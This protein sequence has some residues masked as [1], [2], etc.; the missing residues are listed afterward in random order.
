MNLDNLQE[1][2]QGM[3]LR[4]AQQQ[5]QAQHTSSVEQQLELMVTACSEIDTALAQVQVA[6]QELHLDEQEL[7]LKNTGATEYQHYQKLFEFTLDSD[8]EAHLKSLELLHTVVTNAPVALYAMNS[9]GVFILTEGKGLEALGR[10]PGQAVGHS[11][12]ELYCNYPNI[13]AKINSCLAGTTETWIA[14]F[15]EVVYNTHTTPLRDENGQIIGMIGVATDITELH[16]TE[17]ALRESEEKFR[18]LAENIREVFW[19]LDSSTGQVLYIS[20][21]YVRVWGRSC[22]SLYADR[23]SFLEAVHPEDRANV[24]A[25]LAKDGQEE[26]NDIEYRIVQ[27]SGEVRWIH[28][29]FFPVRNSLGKV[30]R[31]VGIAEDITERKLADTQI[32]E[33]LREKEI[34]LQEIHHRVKNNLQVISSLLDLQS[35]Y[36]EDPSLQ[37]IFIDCCSRIKSIALVHESLYQSKSF[38]SINF[39]EYIKNLTGYLFQIYGEKSTQ[40]ELGLDIE[41][42]KFNINT[43]VTCGLII[44]ELVSNALKHAFPN[45]SRGTINIDFYS[46]SN[47]HHILTVKDNGIGFLQNKNVKNIKSLGIQLV[48][49]LSAQLEGT[50]EIDSSI[51]TQFQLKFSG[52][53]ET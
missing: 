52:G 9:E 14:K 26:G 43:T 45:D 21:A 7:V 24:I 51:G 34:L 4:L 22:E 8:K 44:N 16:Q 10:K 18:Q 17:I 27:P 3:R 49:I 36:I 11:V 39:S 41:D 47:N 32:K 6:L 15:N 28:A 20:P 50:L 19:L 31:F 46:D 13:L 12:F 35:Q 2:I 42:A 1:Q 38:A 23:F 48:H 37:A 53:I 25:S 40:I 33:S 29:R 30:Y 5:Q